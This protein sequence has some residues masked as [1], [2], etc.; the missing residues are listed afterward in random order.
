MSAPGAGAP[1]GGEGL[2]GPR[3]P[4]S[5]E[6]PSRELPSAHPRT[7]PRT[8]HAGPP[9]DAAA[10]FPGGF[11]VLLAVHAGADPRL[12]ARALESVERSTLRP[13]AWLVVAD[14]PLTGALDAEL[15]GREARGALRVLRL[16]RNVGLA[17]A[18]NAG[19]REVRTEWVAR[20][21]ADDVNLPERFALQAAAVRARHGAVDVLGGAIL[22][23]EADGSP[24]AVRAVPATPEA[25]ARRLPARNPFNHMTVA[26]RAEVVRRAGGYPEVHLREDYALWGSL[27][28]RGARCENLEAILVHASGGRSMYGR[29]GGLACARAEWALQRHLVREGRKGPLSA[30]LWG[31]VRCAGLLLPVRVRGLLYERLLRRRRPA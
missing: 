26:Y 21:D 1:A 18:L 11:T 20:A 15:Q 12:F 7:D 16:P 9:A 13:E 31:A 30:L 2:S 29:R 4:P 17:G 14:G 23:V 3:S 6:P 25:I 19:L 24:V 28:A 5:R 27:L 22:E 10:S 8:A